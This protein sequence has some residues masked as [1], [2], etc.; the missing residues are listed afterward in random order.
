MLPLILYPLALAGLAAVPALVAIYLFRNRY[1]RHPVSSLMLWLDARQ[2]RHGGPRLRRLQLPLLFLFELL[3]ILL[4]VFAAT[5]PHLRL[6]AGARPLVVVL[7]DS[8]SMTAGGDD[9][10]RARAVA[11]LDDEIR[12][13]RPY[14]IRF[15]L[16]G[17]RPQALGEVVPDA[18]Q[19]RRVVADWRPRAPAARLQDAIA[20]AAQVGGELA[21]ILVLTDQ[22]PP[23]G[24][25]ADRGRLRW[26]SFGRPRPNVAIV[27]ANRARRDG[28][29]RFLLEI[30]NLS[31]AP[32]VAE[33]ALAPLAGGPALRTLSVALKA[34]E[35]R[36]V[37]DALPPNT[38]AVRARLGDDELAIDN[39]AVLMPAQERPVRVEMRVRD[40]RLR[41]PV[42]KGLKAAGLRDFV[43]KEPHLIVSDRG[44]EPGAGDAW[45]V[46]LL[47]ERD[48]AAYAGPFILD[49]AHPLIDGLS[50]KGVVWGAG[51]KEEID[52]T[53]LV[54]AGNVPLVTSTERATAGGGTRYEVRLRFRP[55]LSTL[56]DSPDWPILMANLLS[57]R[58]AALPG[59]SQTSA[60]LGDRVVLSL[61]VYREKARLTPPGGPPREVPVRGRQLAVVGD[62]VGVYEIANEDGTFSFAVNATSR[63][64]SD[65][66]GAAPGVW[67]SW[68][69][70]TA[71]R[72]EYRGMAWLLLLVALGVAVLHL[73]LT[74]WRAGS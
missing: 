10:P 69:D 20:R 26:L 24:S 9:S 35:S 61:P 36:P 23:E 44:A 47:A 50:P 39:E 73:V 15:V 7:D 4:L 67:G 12:K 34:G 70:D 11:A 71:L 38:P 68:L 40:R 25:V 74:R 53:P 65:L 2:S 19:A 59:L 16:A 31:D 29:D 27:N 22:P 21:L 1:R 41:D 28:V 51:K 72:L 30:A 46:Q 3:A 8:F 56:Q 49:H 55:D 60:R 48:A 58:E 32:R 6:G 64:E 43:V 18:R 66:R 37:I 52:G 14:S 42:E 57:W 62:E 63:D 13:Q 45:V 33:V 5:D 54:L 17:E